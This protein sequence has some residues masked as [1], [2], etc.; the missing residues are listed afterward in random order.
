MGVALAI[1]VKVALS[2]VFTI[3]CEGGVDI[4]A[5]EVLRTAFF[6]FRI[7]NFLFFHYDHFYHYFFIIS[8][9]QCA[10]DGAHVV[11]NHE[12]QPEPYIL[13]QTVNPAVDSL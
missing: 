10:R 8:R 7:N 9:V 6:L 1:H 5:R 11:T 13:N 2:P 4:P 12:T 3:V